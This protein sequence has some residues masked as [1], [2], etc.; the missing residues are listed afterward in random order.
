MCIR[1][2]ATALLQR[3]LALDPLSRIAQELLGVALEGRGRFTE[4][5]R[6]YES[7]I[8][9]Y[10]D[11]TTARISLAELLRSQGK[12]DEA[13]ELLDDEKLMRT[14]PIS[15][16]LLANCYLNLGMPNEMTETLERIR[17]PPPA[18][19]IAHAA[20]LLRSRQIDELS[21]YAKEQL[22]TTRDPIWSSIAI[23]S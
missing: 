17:E 13:V 15:G 14:D 2:R 3:A 9:L 20:L 19:V 8:D 10:P 23:V 6:Q 7:L 4:A 1:D 21:A 22:E 5:R 11:F 16:F 18:A 12:L